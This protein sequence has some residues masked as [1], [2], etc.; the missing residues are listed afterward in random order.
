MLNYGTVTVSGPGL[1]L[2]PL[3]RIERPLALRN[4]ITAK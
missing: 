1:S 2:E 4:A 3:R